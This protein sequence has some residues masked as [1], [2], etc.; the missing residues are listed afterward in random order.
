MYFNE[1]VVANFSKHPLHLL[2][3]KKALDSLVYAW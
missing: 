1:Q 3:K 2:K